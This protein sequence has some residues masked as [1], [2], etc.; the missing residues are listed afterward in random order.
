MARAI[1]DAAARATSASLACDARCSACDDVV[2]RANARDD[3]SSSV[4]WVRVCERLMTSVRDEND[5]RADAETRARLVTTSF[6][7]CVADGR[8]CVAGRAF[9][10]ALASRCALG[11][12]AAVDAASRIVTTLD[13]RVDEGATE[14]WFRACVDG[15]W[16][17]VTSTRE[18]AGGRAW[19][20][21][22]AALRR[23]AS[24]AR[25]RGDAEAVSC[26]A[27]R[28]LE[29]LNE[30]DECVVAM[31]SRGRTC[32]R[33]TAARVLGACG[34][35]AAASGRLCELAARDPAA[36]VRKA[37]AEA[38][39]IIGP[40][41]S[42]DLRIFGRALGD[43][44]D[45]VRAA[46][47]RAAGAQGGGA[48]TLVEKMTANATRDDPY[49]RQSTCEALQAVWR[50]R[51]GEPAQDGSDDV[52]LFQTAACCGELTRD[53]DA[54]VRAAATRC[55]GHLRGAA[56]A[57][58]SL[59][60]ALV[61]D[62]DE[63]VR[64]AA[65]ETLIK[66]GFFNPSTGAMRQKG[67]YRTTK[68]SANK[69]LFAAIAAG[70]NADAGVGRPTKVKVPIGAVVRVWWPLD[71][72]YYEAKVLAYDASTR[73]H[74][75]LYIDD[76]VEEKVN[77]RKEKV[78]LKHKSGKR[79]PTSWIPCGALP[80]KPKTKD[81]S[82]VA[83]K[84]AN[85]KAS[86]TAAAAAAEKKR[87]RSSGAGSWIE[88][89]ANAQKH[90]D[91]GY[92]AI[93]GRRV[94]VWWPLDKAWYAAEVR[95]RDAATNKFS[96]YY[97]EDCEEETLD[98]AKERV[99]VYV[100]NDAYVVPTIH[101]LEPRR[102]RVR[103]GDKEGWYE[104]GCFRGAECVSYRDADDVEITVLCAEFEKTFGPADAAMRRW[105]RTIHVVPPDAPEPVLIDKF[106]RSRGAR[107]GAAV[108]GDECVIDV[109]V[110]VRR[111]ADDDGRECVVEPVWQR[112]KILAY[113][114]AS[115][116]H[117]VVDVRDDGTTD[118][119]RAQ[120]LPLFAQRTKPRVKDDDDDD[121]A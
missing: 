10:D 49:L 37:C 82:V 88:Y 21:A 89:D 104:P 117:E 53:A 14:R 30:T 61:D 46:A 73:E 100:P 6:A 29:V 101:G 111:A 63:G 33:M 103:A 78:D 109:N 108:V 84:N 66:L 75:L 71:G 83:K 36:C 56:A 87:K 91:G 51:Q 44:R 32:A 7:V 80:K 25:A 9:V 118:P 40:V 96:V 90:A 85:S 1:E 115:G 17:V 31:T 16:R 92:D 68:F 13:A 28:A 72:R 55:L 38:I 11:D 67:N 20:R 76:D 95:S 113:N 86:S 3:D 58:V 24:A 15:G 48:K 79:G 41:K 47:T 69:S 5:A 116:E 114:D 121:D 45:D 102:V 120:W 22:S 57:K 4:D 52:R 97:F 106:L 99:Q 19:A 27:T 98:F 12:A 64:D 94:K 81:E 119:S 112:V 105:R 65:V 70:K 42:A 77:F 43:K 8:A 50:G 62:K 23:C 93:V 18:V 39:E 60:N 35:G 2:T 26:I 59:I 110:D 54:G 74:T 34:E 107:W